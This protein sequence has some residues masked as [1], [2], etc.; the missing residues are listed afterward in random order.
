MKENVG[1][2]DRAIRSIVG[3]ALLVAGYGKWG[4]REGRPLG[5]LSMIA[6]AAVIGSAVTRVCPANAALGLDTRSCSTRRRDEGSRGIEPVPAEPEYTPVE[7]AAGEP[8]E[9]RPA[10]ATE[11]SGAIG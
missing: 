7:M 8:L 2:L 5:I 3:P 11:P 4:G 6:G 10:P 9:P 1:N